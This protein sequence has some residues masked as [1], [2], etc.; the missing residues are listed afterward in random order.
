MLCW[1][2]I[3]PGTVPVVVA[4]R[5]LVSPY[6]QIQAAQRRETDSICL[7]ESKG[8]EQN[9]CKV[10]QRI[11]LDTIQDHQGNKYLN[12]SA[13]ITLLL[14][15]RCSPLPPC[16]VQIQLRSKHLSPFKYLE[17]LPKKNGYKRIQISPDCKD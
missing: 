14:G 3:S 6:P 9:L 11:L 10:S 4:T 5:V 12:E 2:Q 16:P 1:L 15:F 7:G 8:R 17:S 13:T